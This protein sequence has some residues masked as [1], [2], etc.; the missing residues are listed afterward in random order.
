MPLTGQTADLLAVVGFDIALISRFAWT[1]QR[2]CTYAF[3][4]VSRGQFTFCLANVQPYS[5]VVL[6][7]L[8]LMIN[9]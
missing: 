1:H 5:S 4:A 8:V 7:R 6:G 3:R 2:C 9:L